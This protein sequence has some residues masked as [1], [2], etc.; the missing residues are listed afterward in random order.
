MEE[1]HDRARRHDFDLSAHGDL[2]SGLT[3]GILLSS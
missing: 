3:S 2:G 1:P